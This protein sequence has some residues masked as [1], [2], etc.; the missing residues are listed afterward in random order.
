MLSVITPA[1]SLPVEQIPA[2]GT[3]LYDRYIRKKFYITYPW[4]D[5]NVVMLSVIMMSDVAPAC[6][7]S[8]F[9]QEGPAKSTIT[10]V[11]I[12]ILQAHG[13]DLGLK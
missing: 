3:G 2:I 7:K 6:Q 12:F 10:S 5:L 4:K 11:K 13:K 8:R 9:P 1:S